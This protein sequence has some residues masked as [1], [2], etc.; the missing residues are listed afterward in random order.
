MKN[1]LKAQHALTRSF[2]V[3]AL[4]IRKVT[5]NKGKN[6]YGIDKIVLK[7]NEE[8]FKAILDVKNLSSYK[9]QSVSR[10]YILKASSKL[11]FLGILVV[12]DRIV[13]TLY[14]FAIDSMAEKTACK[15]SYRFLLHCRLHDNAKYLKFV[16]GS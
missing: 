9:A 8:K 11:R 13:Q 15:R 3:R 14:Y 5:S 10:V 7:T 16:L 6:I 2:A 1:V 4:V 12:R